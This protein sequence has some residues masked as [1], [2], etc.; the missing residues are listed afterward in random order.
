MYTTEW[1]YEEEEEKSFVGVASAPPGVLVWWFGLF[2]FSLPD[3]PRTG[4]VANAKCSSI[5]L[6][7]GARSVSVTKTRT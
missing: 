5:G 1:R 3:R 2:D 6:M 4:S 7:V